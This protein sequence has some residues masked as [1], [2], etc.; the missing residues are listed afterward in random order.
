MEKALKLPGHTAHFVNREALPDD[1]ESY[2]AHDWR[3]DAADIPRGKQMQIFFLA[4][5]LNRHRPMP[6]VEPVPEHHPLMSQPLIELCLRIPSYQ[7]LRGGRQRALARDVFA[8]RVPDEILRREDKGDTT[9][10]V[11]DMIRR[12][13]PFIRELLLDGMLVKHNVI[14]RKALEPY[15]VQGQSFRVEHIWPLLSCIATELWTQTWTRSSL[16]AAT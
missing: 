7:L 2:T 15:I 14:S 5:L 3:M 16:E 12:S 4:E 6:N 1:M 8:D 10:V 13:E 9:T 11:T